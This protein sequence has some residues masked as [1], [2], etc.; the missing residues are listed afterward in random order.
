MSLTRNYLR[1]YDLKSAERVDLFI[2]NSQFVA[3][4]ILRIYGRE[5]TVI[6]PPVDTGFFSGLPRDGRD[7]YLYAG[8]LCFYKR[9]DI[10]VGAFVRN[11][12]PLVV[13]G[14][15]S[16]AAALRRMAAGCP[17]IMFSGRVDDMTLRDLYRRCRALI[18][19]GIEDF[20]IVPVEA[21]AAG[22]PVLALAA[23]GALET[24][25]PGETGMFFPEQ[26]VNSLL[27]AIEEFETLTFDPASIR[28]H[29]GRFSRDCFKGRISSF[30]A[31]ETPLGKNGLPLAGGG[32]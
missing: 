30:L 18:F 29:A 20:G 17:N 9:P 6:H 11:G 3:G 8:E 2:A 28:N 31:E 10:V 1:A 15:G 27:A 24:V 4:R 12:K 32:Q 19:P 16:E 23:G 13:A 25:L 14:C 7:F 26:S 22:A 21:Q 5:A